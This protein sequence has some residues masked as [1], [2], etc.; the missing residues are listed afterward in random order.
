[1]YQ[2]KNYKIRTTGEV[3]TREYLRQLY[4]NTSF[5]PNWTEDVAVFLNADPI[6]DILAPQDTEYRVWV[7]DGYIQDNNTKFWS[8]NWKEVDKY[9]SEERLAYNMQM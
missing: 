3:V 6:L 2:W 7:L 5:P 9:T 4:Y 8:P 1:M